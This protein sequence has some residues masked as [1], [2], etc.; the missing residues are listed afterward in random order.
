MRDLRWKPLC[1]PTKLRQRDSLARVKGSF[2]LARGKLALWIIGL[3]FQMA[4]ELYG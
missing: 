4:F 1:F 3:V 2:R